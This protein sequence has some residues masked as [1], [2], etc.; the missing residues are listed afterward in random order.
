[1]NK[2]NSPNV[3]YVC[4]LHNFKTDDYHEWNDHFKKYHPNYLEAMQTE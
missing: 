4:K 1:M 3:R 2:P